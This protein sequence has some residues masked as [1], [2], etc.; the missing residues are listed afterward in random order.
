MTFDSAP[1]SDPFNLVCVSFLA[2]FIAGR[3]IS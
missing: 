3:D 2:G 1:I